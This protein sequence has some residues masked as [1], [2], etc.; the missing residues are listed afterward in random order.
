VC[1]E[2]NAVVLTFEEESVNILEVEPSSLKK[3]TQMKEPP[4]SQG[5]PGEKH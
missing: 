5:L 1:V 4:S 2:F 3:L